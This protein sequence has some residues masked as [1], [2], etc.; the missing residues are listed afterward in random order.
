DRVA[1]VAEGVESI[2]P[3]PDQVRR[4][5]DVRGVAGP[6]RGVEADAAG[7]EGGGEVRG[8]GARRAIG[9]AD[10]QRRRLGQGPLVLEEGGEQQRLERRRGAE[11]DSVA[12][13]VAH[14]GGERAEA[15]VL[16]G[17]LDKWSQAHGRQS[18]RI[19]R[20]GPCVDSR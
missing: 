7:S 15:R 9:G 18:A 14:I 6:P 4:R 10:Q 2:D 19:A 5:G 20:S 13:G 17:Y 11:L 8:K 1:T 12:V 16:G 3:E